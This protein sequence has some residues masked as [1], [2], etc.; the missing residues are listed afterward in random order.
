M[1]PLSFVV[2]GTLIVTLFA[3]AGASQLRKSVWDGVYTEEQAKRGEALYMKFCASCH[4][5]GLTGQEQA[6]ALLGVAFASTWEGTPLSELLE[7]M[8]TSMPEDNPGSLSR[9]ENADILAHMLK[10]AQFPVG[11]TPLSADPMVLGQ[12]RY[13]SSR[14]TP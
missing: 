9:Q 14:K 2:A 8:R 7:R 6:P 13:D 4:A 1:K 3:S 10:A 11:P 12:I 5:E